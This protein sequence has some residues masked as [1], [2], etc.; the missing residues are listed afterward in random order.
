MK[1]TILAAV[2][3]FA[4]LLQAGTQSVHAAEKPTFKLG[5]IVFTPWMPWG[6]AQQSGI[7]KKWA[8][9]YNVN[10]ELVQLNDYVESLNQYSAG[11]LD[12]VL[13]S[14]ADVYSIPVANGVDTTIFPIDYSNGAD[15]IILKNK[16]KLADIKGQ[17]VHLVEFSVSH[18]LLDRALETG[19]LKP[20][21]VKRVNTSDADFVAAYKSPDVSAI[22]AW[23][24][25]VEQIQKSGDAHIVFD[26]SKINGEIFESVLLRTSKLKENPDV[27]KALLGAWYETVGIINGTSP[28]RAGVIKALATASATDAA[29]YEQ[30]L[31]S[32]VLFSDAK[33]ALAFAERPETKDTLIRVRD[34]AHRYNL[35]GKDVKD[36][37]AIGIE[38]PNGEVVGD[39]KNVLLRFDRSVLELAAAGKL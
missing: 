35:L 32:V 17:T 26:S 2:L 33:A 31:K 20:D 30:Q 16:D 39:S 4:A 24:P 19:N 8:D 9:K 38:L 23:N 12:G 13:G 10:I 18:Y 27:A 11:G 3:A 28:E 29:G 36:A 6:Y 14:I 22:V 34:F 7:L 25:Q 1:R 21:D 15:A 37:N 5:W